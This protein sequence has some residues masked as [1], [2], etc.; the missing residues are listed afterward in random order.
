MSNNWVCK[1]CGAPLSPDM[2][3]CEYCKAANPAFTRPVKIVKETV[4]P[5]ETPYVAPVSTYVPQKVNYGQSF[6][7]FSELT[8]KVVLI[9]LVFVAL[10]FL[11]LSANKELFNSSYA[12]A[13]GGDG[14]GS[15]IVILVIIFG[16]L[17]GFW[18]MRGFLPLNSN[19][20]ILSWFLLV[21]LA[22][23]HLFCLGVNSPPK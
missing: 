6:F 18:A 19:W 12:A 7:A 16:P 13:G 1:S 22:L 5:K 3:K 2:E 11:Y 23:T 17:S 15:F 14:V 10:S 4:Y 8:G 9:L 20:R 21:A